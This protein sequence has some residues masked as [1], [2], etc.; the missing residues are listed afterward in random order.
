MSKKRNRVFIPLLAVIAFSAL[1]ALNAYSCRWSNPLRN[2]PNVVPTAV[3]KKYPE[4]YED[5]YVKTCDEVVDVSEA[6]AGHLLKLKS[7]ILVYA[8]GYISPNV[9]GKRVT[10]WGTCLL[11][12]KGYV[13]ADGVHVHESAGVE[14]LLSA[15]GLVFLVF[16]ILWSGRKPCATGLHT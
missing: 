9:V 7:G 11:M 1:C 12:S 16:Y 5:I 6:E 2:A 15:A 13:R 4:E 14:H 10:V 3:L 8:G